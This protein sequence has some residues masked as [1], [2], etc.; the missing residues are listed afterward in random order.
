VLVAAMDAAHVHR[1]KSSVRNHSAFVAAWLGIVSCATPQFAPPNARAQA[2]PLVLENPRGD[3]YA[4]SDS[5]SP[6]GVQELGD[7][8]IAIVDAR[9]GDLLES[10]S[11][12][13]HR[14]S[15]DPGAR[16]NSAHC[17]WNPVQRL[18]DCR[19]AP[20]RYRV[21][22]TSTLTEVVLSRSVM[23]VAGGIAQER[24]VYAGPDLRR[25][26]RIH[27]HRAPHAAANLSRESVRLTSE[28]T[29]TIFLPQFE[30][31][32]LGF[33]LD[34]IPAGTYRVEIDDSCYLRWTR[35]AV[36]PGVA[37]DAD[38]E[39]SAAVRLRVLDADTGEPAR[40]C[41][42]SVVCE[43]A[44][45]A[46]SEYPL[47]SVGT[48]PSDV[49]LRGLLPGTVRLRVRE[50]DCEV[51]DMLLADLRPGETRKVS[52]TLSRGETFS[53][54]VVRGGDRRPVADVPVSLDPYGLPPSL[55][56]ALPVREI[57]TSSAFA[58][59]SMRTR[60]DA[61]GSFHFDHVPIAG[62]WTVRAQINPWL[63]DTRVL[64]CDADARER[65]GMELELLTFQHVRVRLLAA[66]EMNLA[67]WTMF[68]R[69][70]L[71]EIGRDDFMSER[72]LES[73]VDPMGC[74]DLGPL[75]VGPVHLELWK[76][77]T[78]GPR[79][80]LGTLD[81]SGDGPEGEYVIDP[82]ATDGGR[83]GR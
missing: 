1:E 21:D 22:A 14:E 59:H 72:G 69:P 16:V 52:M 20:D 78:E 48:S 45:G 10:W 24:L 73:S 77:W 79:L 40:L 56:L 44:A 53:G 83:R 8:Q 15:S 34:D 62:R 37:I 29:G 61:A 55:T 13:V 25:R 49:T 2:S 43:D 9:D 27:V 41:S 76:D 12:E 66:S 36:S 18:F 30:L 81:V 5:R 65:E 17:A 7:L 23:V 51:R 33:I 46:S 19:L 82:R 39:G 50:P 71:P 64:A 57:P 42:M 4:G 70:L 75:P 6:R 60:T 3:V 11:I 38:L 28:D 80:D 74:V 63:A 58:P 68:A 31:T 32:D 35:S 26:V 47:R 54:R 67:G